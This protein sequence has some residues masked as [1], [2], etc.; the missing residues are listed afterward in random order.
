M[1]NPMDLQTIKCEICGNGQF[2]RIFCGSDKLLQIDGV[3][4]ILKCKDCGLFLLSPKISSE[5]M[6]KYYPE[7]YICYL[8]AIEDEKNP[9]RKLDRTNA[10]RKRCRQITKRTKEPGKILDIGCA[11]GIFLNGMKNLGWEVTGIEPNQ[12]AAEYANKRFGIDVFPGYLHETTLSNDLFDVITLWDV[13]EHVPDANAFM[14]RLFRLLKPGGIIIGTLPNA[15]AWERRLFGEYWVGWE[16]P[17]H[18][19]SF[20]PDTISQFLKKH[21][22]SKIDIFS[23]IGR[24]GA[25]MLSVEFWLNSSSLSEWKKKIIKSILGSILVRI[26]TYPYFI[27]AEIFNRSNVMSFS[28]QKSL[29]RPK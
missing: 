17:R 12:N 7:E 14:E 4:C 9:L 27:I 2:E 3:F 20:T 22:F 26:F 29:K 8:E 11:T 13:L 23:F 6:E 19:R 5:D 15:I 25:F 10:L 18:Y 21:S 24:H 28:A 1:I 16:I